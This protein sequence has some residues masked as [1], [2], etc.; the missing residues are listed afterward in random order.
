MNSFRLMQQG[1]TYKLLA[2][3]FLLLPGACS[4]A[5]GG[6][7]QPEA[8]RL[9]PGAAQDDDG[10]VVFAADSFAAKTSR[11]QHSWELR[12]DDASLTGSA[13][14]ALP[15]LNATLNTNLNLTSPRLD[16]RVRFAKAGTHYLWVYGR[17]AAQR[18]LSGDS[19]H[20]GLDGA[21]PKS[22]SRTGSFA[23][24]YG[25]GNRVM[26]GSVATL[27]VSAP[28]LHTLNVWMR[29]DGFRLAALALSSDPR[30][31]PGR[32]T[33]P[34]PAPDQP[35][36]SPTPVRFSASALRGSVGI[37]IH[38][39]YDDTAYY[40]RE[41]LL[42]Y[43]EDLGPAWV[44]EGAHKNPRP[45]HPGFLRALKTAGFKLNL[46]VGDPAGSY[47]N[48]GTGDS[49]A[50]IKSLK[51]TYSGRYDQLEL[52]NEWD[53]FSPT[54]NWVAELSAFYDEYYSAI[55]ED[56]FFNGVRFVGPSFGRS[57][58]PGKFTRGADA[59]NL[60]PYSGGLMPEIDEIAEAIA[61]AKGRSSTGEVVATELGY[62]NAVNTPSGFRG[63]PEDVAAHY[64]IR[65]LLW[66]FSRGV[67][68]NYIY[69]LFDQKPTDPGRTE[70]EEWFGLVAVEGNPRSSL[71]TWTLRKKP[72]FYAV[73]RMQAYLEDGGSG[74]VLQT[75]PF[76][77]VSLPEH[78]VTLP[79]A[80]K[81]GSYDLAV[82]LKNPL[83]ER[84]GRTVIADTTATATFKFG[85]AVNV[86]S[87][88]PSVSDEAVRV[89]SGVTE[90]RVAVD[91]KVTFFRVKPVPQ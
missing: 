66:N 69:Q 45:W 68:Q 55:R 2:L 12:E 61:Q 39:T 47:G 76:E 48:F 16:Y 19:L 71:E 8:A 27:E 28:G 54:G 40:D 56:P 33:L 10:L 74:A 64:L 30:F 31:R 7:A 14:V 36:V 6:A 62:H 75:P 9:A 23:P 63:V 13:L 29:E 57:D 4:T 86:D 72:A 34:T 85:S 67:D 20:V 35:G 77:A 51:T 38:S 73:D 24:S 81:D 41:R 26:S 53:L 88:R 46:G 15:D 90:L 3:G 21:A 17:A 42:S 91:G 5:P 11:G 50:L 79:L 80:R 65:T 25:W 59:A 83:W 58:S 43:L 37:N 89:A 1:F 22:S 32:A 49:A 44:R 70:M 82:W 52:P 60:H 87:L 18:S 78:A 84:N